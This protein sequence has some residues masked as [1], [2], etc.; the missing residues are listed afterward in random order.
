ME[1]ASSR[2]P[3]FSRVSRIYELKLLYDSHSWFENSNLSGIWDIWVLFIFVVF[4]GEWREC[5]HLT[6]G[7][8]VLNSVEFAN[9]TNWWIFTSPGT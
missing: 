3:D 8:L 2:R 4:N 9:T 1:A 7:V 5:M 6:V